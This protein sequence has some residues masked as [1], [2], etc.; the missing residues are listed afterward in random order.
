[1][2]AVPK[3]L[4]LVYLSLSLHVLGKACVELLIVEIVSTQP[5]QTVLKNSGFNF[6]KP[7]TPDFPKP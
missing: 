4:F 6:S 3:V 5:C 7:R 2:R 1:M